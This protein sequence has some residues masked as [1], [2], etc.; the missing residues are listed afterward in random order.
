MSRNS[1]RDQ[2]RLLEK[3]SRTPIIEL[4]CKQ[5]GIPRSTFYRWRKSDPAFAAQ[6]D[7]A[8]EQ[9]SNLIND[10]AE[11]QLIS[12]IKERSMPAITFWLKHRHRAYAAKLQVDATHHVY[13]E[14]LTPEQQ[15]LVD[16][17]LKLSGIEGDHDRAT[18]Q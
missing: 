6:C 18:K 5:A 4:A 9:S 17:A 11:S 10:M 7:E 16:Q 15:K 8:L 2:A 3:L 1:N 14:E 13:S 12:A